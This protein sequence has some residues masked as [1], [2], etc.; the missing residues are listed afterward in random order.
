MAILVEEQEIIYEPETEEL[1]TTDELS[2]LE[3]LE[4]EDDYEQEEEEAII[5][6]TNSIQNQYFGNMNVVSEPSGAKVYFD[7]RQVGETPLDLKELPVGTY[8]LLII[9]PG[10]DTESR[11][12]TVFANKTASLNVKLSNYRNVYVST[13]AAGDKVYVDDKYA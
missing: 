11:T 10:Y 6:Q 2:A 9:K 1:E 13:G 7:K 4:D 3:T 5:E 8:Y 12:V